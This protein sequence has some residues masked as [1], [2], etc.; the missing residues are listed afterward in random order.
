[1]RFLRGFLALVGI[2][3]A[4]L[5]LA[6]AAGSQS[7]T[8]RVL[9]IEL[10]NDVNPVTEDFVTGRIAEANREGF[11]AVVL[12]LDTPGGLDSSMRAIIKD[13]LASRVP[14]VVYVAPD[15][16]RAGSAGAF[17]TV[18]ADVAAMAPQTNIGSSTPVS[19]T[20]EDIPTDL[21]RKI[22][23]DAAAYIES[24]A[25]EHGRN[26][27]EAK[28]F[29]TQG[30]NLTAREALERNVV[31]VVSP[32]LS[33]LLDEIDGTRTTP[34]GIVLETAGAEVERVEMSLWQRILDT[35][36]DP[37]IITLL[38]SLGVLGIV[39]EL[40]NPG[41]V[42]PAT[43]GAISLIVSLFG[44]Q[45][46]PV[47]WAGIL[48]L[49]LAFAFFAA[50]VFVTSHGA[51]SVA[52]AVCFVF[53][54]LLLFEPAGDAYRVSIWVAVAIAGTL[55]VL[56]GAAGIAVARVRGRT[57]QVGREE[58]VGQ[59]AIVRRALDP[60]G[61]VFVHGELW[62]ARAAHGAVAPGEAVRVDEIGDELVL[63]VSPVG[64]PSAPETVG[65]VAKP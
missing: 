65:A 11:D 5:A 19:T 9:V 64:E 20:G 46:L 2:A 59:T 38:L 62:R 31:D 3:V 45:V 12:E 50:E 40:W 14:V 39:V 42:F 25:N 32:T 29:V 58:L 49:A 23:N 18:A 24:L 4:A 36:V 47:S 6:G 7:E 57:P 16:A 55:A 63:D 35:I 21:R 30:A 27:A 17:I 53:G 13:I 33:A 15:G 60:E 43:F 22:V 26:G 54:A 48:L 52:G 28:L 56:L 34:K 61:L 37:N 10:D 51:L 44:L 41:L 1:M 8:N